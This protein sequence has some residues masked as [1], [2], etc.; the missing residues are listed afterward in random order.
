MHGRHGPAAALALEKMVNEGV[1]ELRH[2]QRCAIDDDALVGQHGHARGQGEQRV[3]VVRD[4]DHGEAELRVQLAQQRAEVVGAVGV[5]PRRR[6]VEQQQRRVHDERTCQRH[7]LDHA[8]RQ[9]G[10]HACG[11]LGLEAH[12]L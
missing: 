9:V 5:E 4:H 8:A 1:V 7:A 3:Q 2:V 12:E 11:V 6:L 10:R